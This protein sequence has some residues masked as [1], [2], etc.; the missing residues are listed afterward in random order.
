M[1][2]LDWSAKIKIP[3]LSKIKL[4]IL[5]LREKYIVIVV[6]TFFRYHDAR[7]KGV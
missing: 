1:C 5:R 6:F 2:L 4:I 7:S 3:E